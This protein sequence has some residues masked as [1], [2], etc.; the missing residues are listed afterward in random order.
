MKQ[1]NFVLRSTLLH[2]LGADPKELSEAAR[3]M[4]AGDLSREITL[5]PGDTTSVM[6][7]MKKIADAIK[8]MSSDAAMLSK[9][10]VEG[11]VALLAPMLPS[12]TA[13]FKSLWKVSTRHLMPS[14]AR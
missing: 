12:I 4:A 5:A 13:T 8:S 14:S 10:A 1:F 7:S 11:K 9:A 2:E 6:A 3:L